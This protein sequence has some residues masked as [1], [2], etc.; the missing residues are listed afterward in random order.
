MITYEKYAEIRNS[1]GMKDADVARAAKIPPSTFTEWKKG[2]YTPKF[3]KMCK[4]AEALG[5][6]Y[7]EFV[8]EDGPKD[9]D[10]FVEMPAS[11]K[12][13]EFIELYESADPEIQQAVLTLLKSSK[14]DS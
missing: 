3:D 13:T 2:G 10:R 7:L 5:M 8:G 6:W 4:I 1:K 9:M 14:R 12:Q 11:I